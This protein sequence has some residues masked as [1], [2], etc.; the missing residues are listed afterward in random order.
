MGFIANISINKLN[1][2]FANIWF[3]KKRVHPKEEKL[4]IVNN[5]VKL[6]VPFIAL[7]VICVIAIIV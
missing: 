4:N 2:N 5:G 6:S 7:F 3:N 1:S